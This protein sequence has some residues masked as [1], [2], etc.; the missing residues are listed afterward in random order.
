VSAAVFDSLQTISLNK[1]TAPTNKH[2]NLHS[3]TAWLMALSYFGYALVIS[4]IA[5][6]PELVYV[7]VLL[8]CIL[9]VALANKALS[10]GVS[11]QLQMAYFVLVS[12]VGIIAHLKLMIE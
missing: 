7:P 5:A 10:K 9:F 4:H 1:Q 2:P 6:A 11:L 3:V 8:V 12:T